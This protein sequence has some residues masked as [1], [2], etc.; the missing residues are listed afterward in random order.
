MV[1]AIG[2]PALASLSL[3][4]L[5]SGNRTKRL[6]FGCQTWGGNASIGGGPTSTASQGT[7]GMAAIQSGLPYIHPTIV[8]K[9]PPPAEKMDLPGKSGKT[10]IRI[11]INPQI[12]ASTPDGAM[13]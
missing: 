6:A 1:Y 4:P 12:S 11:L 2:R 10:T 3:T 8:L 13:R 5:P 9:S 7:S